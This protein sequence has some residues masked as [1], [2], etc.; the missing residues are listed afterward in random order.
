VSTA[1]APRTFTADRRV[2]LGD[3]GPDG[4]LRLDGI[5]RYAQ[6]VSD[7]DTRD[8]S[9]DGAGAWLVRRSSIT[10]RSRPRLGEL[11]RLDTR[12]TGTGPRWAEREVTLTVVDDGVG[13][14]ARASVMVS[15]LWVKIDPVT[16]QAEALPQQFF[17]IWGAS[18]NGRTVSARLRHPA[19]DRGLGLAR[20]P[21]PLRRTD[22]DVFGHVNNAAVWEVV[23]ELDLVSDGR[24]AEIEFRLP[25]EGDVTVIHDSDRA[26]AWVVGSG[27]RVLA[28]FAITSCG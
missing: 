3:V 16:M 15:T 21:W 28:S 20:R 10:V 25:I 26:L 4:L 2:R 9:F 1:P 12:C 5:A 13:A 7:D 18:A 27:D 14:D 24:C 22:F 19:P 11:V 17:E 23:E 8:A 6:D